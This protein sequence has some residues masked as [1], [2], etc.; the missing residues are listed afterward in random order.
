MWSEY[1]MMDCC[2]GLLCWMRVI[3]RGS[4]ITHKAQF[5]SSFFFSVESGQILVRSL[6]SCKITVSFLNERFFSCHVKANRHKCKK[7]QPSFIICPST[8]SQNTIDFWSERERWGWKL[9]ISRGS[10]LIR[11]GLFNLVDQKVYL[12]WPTDTL[13]L[14]S[15]THA[16]P[17]WRSNTF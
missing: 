7:F 13:W 8:I 12:H 2:F 11:T 6:V 16:Y 17:L 4:N 3:L 5:G 14:H 10:F 9:G 1:C 15:N